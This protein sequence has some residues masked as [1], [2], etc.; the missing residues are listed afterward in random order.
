MIDELVADDD[1]KGTAADGDDW[2][3][4]E[5]IRELDP[6]EAERII[7]DR[8]HTRLAAIMGY[9]DP[10]ALN[11]AQPLIELGMDSLMAVRIRNASQRDFGIEPPVA[12]LL[13]G[14]SL[15]DITANA[16][17]QLGLAQQD[18]AVEAV[19]TRASQ[20]AAARHGA[21]MRRQ[22]GPRT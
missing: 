12:L 18:S 14:A 6:N 10:S 7:A 16:M 9:T 4:V 8:L 5:G 3:G 15:T 21:S 1:G 19:R 11:P 13:Q 17:T 2:A 20:R 22:R